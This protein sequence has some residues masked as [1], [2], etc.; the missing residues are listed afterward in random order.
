MN[1]QKA[2]A[3]VKDVEGSETPKAKSPQLNQ[4]F[5]E[6]S[7]GTSPNMGSMSEIINGKFLNEAFENLSTDEK[8][9][10]ILTELYK[11]RDSLN[12]LRRSQGSL[13]QQ[14]DTHETA[15]QED[16]N[17][18][19]TVQKLEMVD[20]KSEKNE[21]EIIDLHNADYAQGEEIASIQKKVDENS[22]DI[23]LIK[24][25]LQ[26]QHKQIVTNQNKVTDLTARSM[27]HNLT[28][29]GILEKKDE[30]CKMLALNFLQT[31]MRLEVQQ[32]D[33]VVAHRLGAFKPHN[34]KPRLLVIRV[35]SKLKD[36]ILPNTARLKD[37]VNEKEQPF[38]INIQIPEAM[39]AEKKAMQYE[40]KRVKEYNEALPAGFKKKQFQIKNRKLI[41][42][43]EIKTQQVLPPKPIDTFPTAEEQKWIND[44]DIFTSRPKTEGFC[45]FVGLAAKVHTVN[46]VRQAYIKVRQ[47]YPSFDHAIMAYNIQDSDGYQDDGEHSAAIK[48]HSAMM[49]KGCKNMVIFVV[50]NFG[51]VHLGPKRF[52][53]IAEVVEQATQL[54]LK[55][56]PEH[57][58]FQGSPNPDRGQSI[59]GKSSAGNIQERLQHIATGNDNDTETES[60]DL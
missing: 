49:Q 40:V 14:V 13:Q 3:S 28:I 36:K 29:S 53:C 34:R 55:E 42:D 22:R 2:M 51:G 15:L 57:Q 19:E 5:L 48:I 52:E 1:S 46:Q 50:R 6:H 11:M 26:R 4:G 7:K 23:Q 24:G 30:N 56:N 8:L 33:I 21:N 27:D 39:A 31:E 41:I 9:S 59:A 60:V 58:Q 47:L 18:Q 12:G 16:Q 20:R 44:I 45:Q 32:E 54:L 17:A 35:A 25:T 37:R 10:M 43:N 38:F